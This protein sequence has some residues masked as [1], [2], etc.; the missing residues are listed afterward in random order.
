M[1]HA[2]A[3]FSYPRE[4]A[5][6]KKECH[7]PTDT[8]GKNNQVWCDLDLATDLVYQTTGGFQTSSHLEVTSSTGH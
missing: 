2:K 7:V 1:R 8:L 5:K 4:I 6:V 3:S